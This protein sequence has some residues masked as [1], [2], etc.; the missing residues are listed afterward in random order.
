MRFHKADPNAIARY[1]ER[2]VELRKRCSFP[3]SPCCKQGDFS[4]KY[5]RVYY[6]K[7]WCLECIDKDRS[8]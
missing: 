6:G 1:R 5:G 4:L 3:C 7:W 8:K 2:P